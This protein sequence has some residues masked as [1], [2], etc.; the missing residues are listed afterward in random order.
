MADLDLDSDLLRRLRGNVLVLT[1]AGISVA[2]GLPTFRGNDGLYEGLNP[3]ELASP[4][5]F[6]ERPLTVWNWYAMRIR[7]GIGA[8]PN[9]AHHALVELEGLARGFTL[10]TSN[11][12]PLHERAGSR[13][14]YK[15]HGDIMQTRCLSCRRIEPLDIPRFILNREGFANEDELPTCQ[16]G[17]RLRPN[18]VWFGEYPNYEAME[19]A[20][21]TIPVVDVGIEVG[22]SGVVSYGFSEIIVALG[23]P[24]IRINPDAEVEPGVTALAGAAEEFLPSLVDAVRAS[25]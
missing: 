15:L 7:Q 16:C 8:Q 23:T 20:Q 5:A 13:R 4:D 22:T 14:V 2:S 3:Y 1:G 10:I 18:V 24:L 19:A 9:A 6:A 25:R 11:V 12:D 17:G 21:R